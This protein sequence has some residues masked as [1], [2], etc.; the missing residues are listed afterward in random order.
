VTGTAKS[1]I[2]KK[3]LAKKRSAKKRSAQKPAKLIGEIIPSLSTHF[4][5]LKRS[6]EID[7][8]GVDRSLIGTRLPEAAAN[9]IAG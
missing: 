8:F 5:V 6:D 7:L 4:Q 1:R 2:A 9:V 3:R